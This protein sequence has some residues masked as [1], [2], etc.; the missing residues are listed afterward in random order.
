MPNQGL[1]LP[2]NLLQQ[3]TPGADQVDPSM[4]AQGQG[5]AMPPQMAQ[6]PQQVTIAPT[7][8]E[9]FNQGNPGQSAPQ[10]QPAPQNADVPLSAEASTKQF[11][12]ANNVAV[13]VQ[14]DNTL[15]VHRRNSDG[16]LGPVMKVVKIPSGG[17]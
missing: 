9:P 14:S 8:P 16:S 7:P 3:G 12:P 6:A 1:A 2:Q 11:T 5:L 15:A 10:G 17:G 13:V 4:L